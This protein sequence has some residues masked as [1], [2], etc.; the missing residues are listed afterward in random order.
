MLNKKGPHYKSTLYYKP[1]EDKGMIYHSCE[2]KSQFQNTIEIQRR[3]PALKHANVIFNFIETA[4]QLK[5][6]AGYRSAKSELST[7]FG[8]NIYGIEFV[9]THSLF[10][11]L[12]DK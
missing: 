6:E 9:R 4:I 12:S 3:F 5:V 8:K 10:T 11:L 2:Q 1:G 7:V